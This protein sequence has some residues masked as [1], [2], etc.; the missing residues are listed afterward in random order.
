MTYFIVFS[1]DKSIVEDWHRQSISFDYNVE[2]RVSGIV[3]WDD[4]ELGPFDSVHIEGNRLI[5][6]WNQVAFS[7]ND[8]FAGH[9]WFLYDDVENNSSDTRFFS[10]I[11]INS[12][13]K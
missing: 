1:V 10:D 9:I 13:E 12:E 3:V 6:D 4:L 11:F 2:D 5:C 8:P 7:V